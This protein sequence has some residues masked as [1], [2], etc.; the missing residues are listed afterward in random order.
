M[1]V[2]TVSMYRR[3]EEQAVKQSKNKVY[4]HEVSAKKAQYTSNVFTKSAP[5][6]TNK[7]TRG[8]NYYA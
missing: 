7:T 1:D 2:K 3:L 8:L 4:S 5:F 6:P